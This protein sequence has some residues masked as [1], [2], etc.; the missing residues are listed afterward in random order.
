M[1][2]TRFLRIMDVNII[3]YVILSFI[4]RVFFCKRQRVPRKPLRPKT[5]HLVSCYELKRYV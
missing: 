2:S 1:E 4:F 3:R 5:Q